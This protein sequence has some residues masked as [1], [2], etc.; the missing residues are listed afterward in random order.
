MPEKYGALFECGP[1]IAASPDVA[2]AEW[3]VSGRI[4]SRVANEGFFGSVG[5]GFTVDGRMRKG[6]MGGSRFRNKVVESVGGVGLGNSVG[7]SRLGVCRSVVGLGS[8]GFL[9]FPGLWA[10]AVGP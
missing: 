7:W 2:I 8:E 4:G 9:R 5:S 1:S 10:V 6:G 3:V